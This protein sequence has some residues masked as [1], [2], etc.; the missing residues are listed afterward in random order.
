MPK[1]TNTPTTPTRRVFLSGA[2]AT[3]AALLA[4]PAALAAASPDADLLAACADYHR[5][6]AVF[7]GPYISDEVTD[8]TGRIWQKSV[9]AVIATP[10]R[11]PAGLRA[12]A[13][14]A[15]SVLLL[16][17]DEGVNPNWRED[18]ESEEVLAIDVLRG[19]LGEG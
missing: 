16:N 13:S 5:A 6:H 7:A 11:T 1:A 8:A 19:F 2:T 9:D 15:L 10:H 17:V 4:A 18:A 12:K 3:A 14:V